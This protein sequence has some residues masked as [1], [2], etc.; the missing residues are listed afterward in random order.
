MANLEDELKR[1]LLAGLG[2]VAVTAEK[3]KEMI[4][5]SG[6]KRR[7]HRRTGKSSE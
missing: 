1:I 7:A 2:A 3:A 5:D 4:E 6:E